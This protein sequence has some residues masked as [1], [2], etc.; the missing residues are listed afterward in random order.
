MGQDFTGC[1]D[2]PAGQVSGDLP[3]LL[4]QL[5]GL[6]I[7]A[8]EGGGFAARRLPVIRLVVADDQE[9]VRDGFARS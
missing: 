1:P 7:L 8:G 2:Y 6:V 9:L 5:H 4:K 3:G